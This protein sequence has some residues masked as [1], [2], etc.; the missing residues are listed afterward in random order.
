MHVRRVQTPSTAAVVASAGEKKDFN[1]TVQLQHCGVQLH[2][3][4]P[5]AAGTAAAAAVHSLNALVRPAR[6][7]LPHSPYV[8]GCTLY[9]TALHWC[10]CN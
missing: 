2:A 8:Q 6:K 4:S 5:N 3:A 9:R 1:M 10:C 7:L